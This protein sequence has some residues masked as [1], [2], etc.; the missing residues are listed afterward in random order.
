[1]DVLSLLRNRFA[2]RTRNA[3]EVV[4]AAARK[5]AAGQSV[6]HAALEAAMVATNTSV[7]AFA[8]LV[9]LH[10]TRAGWRA[11]YEKLKDATAKRDKANATIEREDAAFIEYQQKHQAKMA[12]LQAEYREA[13]KVVERGELAR[14]E[15]ATVAN[16]PDPAAQSLRDAH[17]ALATASG[18]VSSANRAIRE[19]NEGIKREE[20]WIEHK[21]KTGDNHMSSK[22][23]HERSL[24]HWK[25]QLAEATPLLAEAIAGERIA[26]ER[27]AAAELEAISA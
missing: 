4:S 26:A 12:K 23:D 2:E 22:A 25:R 18:A 16:V 14:R 15:L 3:A 1:M 24:R 7:D 8:T 27:L 19:A 6:D 21:D 5:V 10:T 13:A 11:D 20:E 17:E 9:E